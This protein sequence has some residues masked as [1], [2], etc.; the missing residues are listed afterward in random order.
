MDNKEKLENIDE[1]LSQCEDVLH[2]RLGEE[3]TQARKLI[4][5]LVDSDSLPPV[6][7]WHLISDKPPIEN[8]Y[9]ELMFDNGL[10]TKRNWKISIIDETTMIKPVYW[11]ACR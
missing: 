7:G 1:V 3:I 11:R 2:G 9:I 4:Q 10:T 5:S 6:I 8:D